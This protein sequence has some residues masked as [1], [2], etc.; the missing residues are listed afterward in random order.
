MPEVK[1]DMGKALDAV[2]VVTESSRTESYK[3]DRSCILGNRFT[4]AVD[5]DIRP[6]YDQAPFAEVVVGGDCGRGAVDC[7]VVVEWCSV[8]DGVGKLWQGNNGSGGAAA[9]VVARDGEW[10][11]GSDRSGGGEHFWV[12]RKSFSAA[13]GGGGRRWWWP[14]AGDGEEECQAATVVEVQ[15]IAVEWWSGARLEMEWGNGGWEIM[16]VVAAMV[17]ARDGEW[18]RG[19]DRSGGGEH[20]W[21]R[22]KS[23]PVATG[24]GGRRWW[25]PVAGD[26]EEECQ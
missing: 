17:V 24:G 8:G 13:T 3:Q 14:A 23:F 18:C 12:R 1:V 5:A 20:F 9:V 21:V 16:A 22:R 26:G 6:L 19:L 2:L 4:Y 15:W 10:C 25:W 11:R 7:G